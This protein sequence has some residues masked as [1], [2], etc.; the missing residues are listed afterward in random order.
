MA[1]V[2]APRAD[3]PGEYYGEMAD[4]YQPRHDA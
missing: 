1:A 3:F 4:L 2:D